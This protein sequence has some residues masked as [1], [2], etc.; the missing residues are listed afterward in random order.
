MKGK[1]ST[2]RPKMAENK[3]KKQFPTK[4]D[5]AIISRIERQSAKE[6]RSKNNLVENILDKNLEK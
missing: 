2:G 3:R 4:L 6:N 5:P 1:K